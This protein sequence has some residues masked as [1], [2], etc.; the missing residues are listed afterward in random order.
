M[1][2]TSLIAEKVQEVI[3]EMKEMGLWKKY[4]PGW[5]NEYQKRNI[6]TEDDFI[7]WLQFV[8]LPNLAQG[9]SQTREGI[10]KVLIVPQAVRFFGVDLAKGK[11][12]R[13]LIELDAM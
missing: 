5:V 10:R 13:L 11:L 3:K 6:L 9:V 8:Y 2:T 7:E 4:T 1:A 12:L